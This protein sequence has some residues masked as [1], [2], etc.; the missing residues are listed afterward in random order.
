MKLRRLLAVSLL[1]LPTTAMAD[2]PLPKPENLPQRT[3]VY[4]WPKNQ[5]TG[6]TL[7]RASFTYRDIVD[8]KIKDKLGSG[9]PVDIVMR[10][11]VY[12]EGDSSPIALS[13]HTCTVKYM[14]WDDFYQVKIDQ[15]TRDQPVVNLDGV[16][17]KCVQVTD[18]IVADKNLLT[19]SKPFFLATIVEV[20][21][22][23]AQMLAELRQWIARP[24]GSTGIGPGD[25]LFGAFVGLFVKQLGNADKTLKFRTQSVVPP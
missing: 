21:P 8:Q 25:A 16:L 20:N 23:S 18:L 11:Y 13:G 3:A 7:F 22:V 9:L 2:D 24:A 5:Q 12:R 10:A 1:L 4:T 14:L 15:A 17:N 6:Q 19:G